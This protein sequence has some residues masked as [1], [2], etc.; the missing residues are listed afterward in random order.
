MVGTLSGLE[1]RL[2]HDDEDGGK[3]VLL[4]RFVHYPRL[5]PFLVWLQFYG[6]LFCRQ[7]S[8]EEDVTSIAALS[9]PTFAAPSNGS[10]LILTPT[11]VLLGA[12][13]EAEASS[14]KCRVT[15]S[16]SYTI[17]SDEAQE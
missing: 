12:E 6:Y 10:L 16:E 3:V 11:P 1:L 17:G 4:N 15:P 2:G 8:M 14:E 5:H 7:K 9:L 13:V